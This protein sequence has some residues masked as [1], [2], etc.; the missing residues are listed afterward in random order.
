MPVEGQGQGHVVRVP[1][2]SSVSFIWWV[3][4][5]HERKQCNWLWAA[6]GGQYDWRNPNRVFIMQDSADRREA[7][8]SGRMLHHMEHVRSTSLTT[9][10]WLRKLCIYSL[11]NNT[12]NEDKH[13]TNYINN[14]YTNTYVRIAQPVSKHLER[15][16]SLHLLMSVSHAPHGSR[17]S[18][19]SSHP[20]S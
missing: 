20:H 6:C 7:K 17:C 16:V 14:K 5:K 9:E 1:S 11:N 18:R 19:V 4:S 3:S 15:A 8:V 13:D 10:N 2:L 12:S